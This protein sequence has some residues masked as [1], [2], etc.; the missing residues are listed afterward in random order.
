MKRVS[1]KMPIPKIL[2][3]VPIYNAVAPEPFMFF[4]VA[5][6]ETGRA[7]VRGEYSVRWMATGPK[8]KIPLVR[9]ISCDQMLKL[10]ADYLAF[11]DDDMLLQPKEIFGRLLSQDKDI[12]SP[13]FFR[14]SG[15]IQPLMFQMNGDGEPSPIE[16]WERGSLVEATGGTGT[17]VMLIK[18]KVLEAMQPPW[19]YYPENSTRSMDVHFCLR[20]IE[21]GFK[22]WC[23]TSIVCKQM[24][25]A[26]PVGEEEYL[27]YKQ[28]T[29][30]Q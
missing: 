1:S 24:G 5:S 9:N 11:V 22:V 13:L 23:D 27:K 12:I 10:G 16:Q 20:A 2:A 14:S 8:V 18:R 19:F 26:Y 3:S 30:T 6:Q 17:G 28:L 15:D 25:K 21:L 7:E 4:M 29:Q